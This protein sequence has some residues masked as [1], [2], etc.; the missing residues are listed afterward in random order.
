MQV[1]LSISERHRRTEEIAEAPA[2]ALPRHAG[3]I[4]LTG[5]RTIDPVRSA[6][7]AGR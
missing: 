4:W 1:P 7:P 2:A 3:A 5:G 6:G